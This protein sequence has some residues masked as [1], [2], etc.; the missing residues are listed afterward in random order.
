VAGAMERVGV[1][2]GM[3]G[4]VVRVVQPLGVMFDSRLRFISNQTAVAIS[5]IP[6]LARVWAEDRRDERA[7]Q[8]KAA[9]LVTKIDDRLSQRRA[10]RLDLDA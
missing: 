6:I 4:C 8:L 5:C 9:E 7:Y 1:H 10:G 3:V 2:A